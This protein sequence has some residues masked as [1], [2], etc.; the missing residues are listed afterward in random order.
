VHGIG[1]RQDD[2]FRNT[3]KGNWTSLSPCFS[4][5]A[6]AAALLLCKV[7]ASWIATAFSLIFIDIFVS[8]RMARPAFQK[9]GHKAS[10]IPDGPRKKKPSSRQEGFFNGISE[11][12]LFVGL[13]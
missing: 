12:L 2:E 11:T 7:D 4:C 8:R 3:G 9:S 10:G 5:R 6:F 1:P 13:V